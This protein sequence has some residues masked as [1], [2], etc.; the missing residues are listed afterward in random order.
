[1][2]GEAKPSEREASESEL[3]VSATPVEENKDKK[4][5]MVL[6]SALFELFVDSK[7]N[8]G[9][10]MKV[11]EEKDVSE[12]LILIDKTKKKRQL[13]KEKRYKHPVVQRMLN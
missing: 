8:A 3:S 5:T 12:N 10:K 13:T 7:E 4:T 6:S 1:M 11:V 9:I 2:T